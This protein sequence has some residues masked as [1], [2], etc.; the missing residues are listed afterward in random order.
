[1]DWHN[2]CLAA[3]SS[4]EMIGRVCQS[5]SAEPSAQGLSKEIFTSL[6]LLRV[7]AIAEVSTRLVLLQ[8][9][10]VPFITSGAMAHD[11]RHWMTK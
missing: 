3:G 9:N 7:L 4:V 6:Q 8:K 5:P 2:A 1:M 10:V 11:C